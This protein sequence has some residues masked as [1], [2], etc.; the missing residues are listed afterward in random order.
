MWVGVK[1]DFFFFF[2]PRTRSG[3]RELSSRTGDLMAGL[4]LVLAG[5]LLEVCSGVSANRGSYPSF[6]DEIPFKITWPGA[7]LTLVC[8]L[9]SV[10]RFLSNFQ[11]K[12]MLQSLILLLE[13]SS[14][15][16]FLWQTL[17]NS[18]LLLSSRPQVHFTAKMTSSLWQQRKKRNT[19]VCCHRWHLETRWAKL[20]A[21]SF[22]SLQNVTRSP[23]KLKKWNSRS[24]ILYVCVIPEIFHVFYELWTKNLAWISN[25][26]RFRWRIKP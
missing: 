25:I 19:N 17:S 18:R 21:S 10:T 12:L 26:S 1:K 24:C 4:L 23:S 16:C 7:E 5:G 14:N 13:F 9:F 22:S 3:L 15:F 20:T 6:T 11:S 2:L 8:F